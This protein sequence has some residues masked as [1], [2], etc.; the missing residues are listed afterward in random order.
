[1]YRTKVRP[2][3]EA[4]VPSAPPAPEQPSAVEAS[5]AT[6]IPELPTVD[7][8][9]PA[10]EATAKASE[11]PSAGEI[12]DAQ[13]ELEQ[14]P[15]DP[16]EPKETDAPPSTPLPLLKQ[17]AIAREVPVRATGISLEKNEAGRHLFHE[18]TTSVLVAETGGVIR[19]SAAVTAGQLLVLAN[20][21]TKH[22]V[23]VQILRKRSYK[24]T[25]CYLEVR[26]F[27]E[28]APRFWGTEFFGG[29]GFAAE[30]QSGCGKR[31]R[32]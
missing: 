32:L 8:S 28:A 10:E 2:E 16:E 7:V 15:G 23:I 31:P 6:K 25:M 22:E 27:V 12:K 3:P 19:L 24:P 17:N 21:E 30:E 29:D 18:E 20:V 14:T 9:V 11:A 26:R 4:V 5:S 1:M 13:P